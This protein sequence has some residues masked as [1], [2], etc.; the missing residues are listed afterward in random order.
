MSDRKFAARVS[1][2]DGRKLWHGMPYDTREEAA[3]AAFAARPEA[4]RCST[5]IAGIMPHN[6]EWNDLGSD[7]RYHDRA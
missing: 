7:I 2:K 1:G 3:A 4:R 5:S 6:G